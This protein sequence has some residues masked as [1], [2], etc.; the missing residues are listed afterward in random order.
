MQWD[1]GTVSK[2]E[3]AFGFLAEEI[4][5][6]PFAILRMRSAFDQR[7]RVRQNQDADPIRILIRVD[8]LD[9]L[10][11]FLRVYSV[12]GINEEK[13]TCPVATKSVLSPLLV[14]ILTALVFMSFMKV[15]ARSSPRS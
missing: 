13:S 15:L 10:A 11:L 4:I 8:D 14:V 2:R 5:D 1:L 12:V 3:F 9:R 6:E 7:D